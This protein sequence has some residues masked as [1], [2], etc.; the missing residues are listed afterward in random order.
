MVLMERHLRLWLL[1]VLSIVV[2]IIYLQFK[3]QA[4]PL[5][6]NLFKALAAVG[7]LYVLFQYIDWT[8]SP[9]VHIVLTSTLVSVMY[10]LIVAQFKLSDDLLRFVKRIGK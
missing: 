8:F 6:W 9:L 7:I 3:I 5:S 2:K 1:L 10:F 4:N